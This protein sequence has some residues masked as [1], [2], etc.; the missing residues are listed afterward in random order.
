[1]RTEEDRCHLISHVSDRKGNSH[2]N[3]QHDNEQH[4]KEDPVAGS[5]SPSPCGVAPQE[6]IIALVRLN[7]AEKR[8]PTPASEPRRELIRML[9]AMRTSTTRGTPTRRP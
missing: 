8:S 7:Q 9:I 3:R 5:R 4:D 6:P 2:H 1:R